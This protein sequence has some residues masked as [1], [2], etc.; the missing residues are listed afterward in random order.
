MRVLIMMTMVMVM[1]MMMLMVG[2]FWEV[3]VMMMMMMMTKQS[4]EKLQ[5]ET[6]IRRAVHERMRAD[7]EEVFR[8]NMFKV[9]ELGFS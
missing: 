9:G 2:F 1:V 6:L 4:L 3:M 8:Q 5:Y 7:D